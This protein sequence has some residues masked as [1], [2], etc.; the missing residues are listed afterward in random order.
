MLQLS[1]V[2]SYGAGEGIRGGLKSLFNDF[3]EEAKL[4]KNQLN[5]LNTCLNI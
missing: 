4:L 1:G 5:L 2:C 3:S